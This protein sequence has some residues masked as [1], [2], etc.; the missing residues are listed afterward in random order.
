MFELIA[1][2]KYIVAF[3]IEGDEGPQSVLVET[4]FTGTYVECNGEELYILEH[5]STKKPYGFTKQMLD[6]NVGW[7]NPEA[8]KVVDGPLTVG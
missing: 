7:N 2:Q 4:I 8:R 1:G 6:A 3:I 5:T